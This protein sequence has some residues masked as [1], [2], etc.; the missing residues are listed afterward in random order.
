MNAFWIILT[1]SLI[2]FSGAILGSM[3]LLRRMAMIADAI[4]H[5]VL[6]GIVLGFWWKGDLNSPY[7]LVGAAV[8]GL[9]T[10]MLIDFLHQKFKLQAD[11]SIGLSFSFL[12]A[13]GLLMI[14]QNREVDL[15]MDCVLFGEIAFL[16]LDIFVFEGKNLGPTALWV[17]GTVFLLIF[18]YFE[19]FY[20]RLLLISFDNQFAKLSGFY[21][22]FWHYSMMLMVSLMTV[23]AFPSVGAILVLTVLIVP[24]A[25]A[26]LFV[27]SLREMVYWA[28][29]ISF[30]NVV[31]GYFFAKMTDGSISGAISMA[32]G[33]TFALV[34]LFVQIRK[35]R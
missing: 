33:V 4:A 5:A 18:S 17:T 28:C 14:A 32:S 27:R 24:A 35:R 13:L 12:F 29:F 9:L 31:L 16:P 1:A 22:I 6:P 7:L 34:L 23:S 19:L 26:Y 10:T 21:A 3:M 25:T 2:G 8:T 20:A 11:A 15:D 30:V